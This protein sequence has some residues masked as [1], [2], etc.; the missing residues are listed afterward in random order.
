MDAFQLWMYGFFFFKGGQTDFTIGLI[1]CHTDKNPALY[2]H[3]ELMK[4]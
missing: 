4:A 1:F 2:K 3:N